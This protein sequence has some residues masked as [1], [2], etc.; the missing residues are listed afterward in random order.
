MTSHLGRR[1]CHRRQLLLR[2]RYHKSSAF[3]HSQLRGAILRGAGKYTVS[4]V[5]ERRARRRSPARTRR[6]GW[7]RHRVNVLRH[8][9]RCDRLVVWWRDVTHHVRFGHRQTY[10]L[11]RLHF[12]R[13]SYHHRMPQ[14]NIL[15]YYIINDC[16]RKIKYYSRGLDDEFICLLTKKLFFFEYYSFAYSI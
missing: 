4:V 5:Q 9:F 12:H 8:R 1:H 13:Y 16:S 11:G 15:L 14:Y 2:R 7:R 3:G 6:P 10:R